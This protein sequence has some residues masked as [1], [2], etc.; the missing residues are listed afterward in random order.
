M[1]LKPKRDRSLLVHIFVSPAPGTVP[2]LVSV[3][4][5]I[6]HPVFILYPTYGSE[7]HSLFLLLASFY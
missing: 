5:M 2:N 1:S 7:G 4:D 3:H 6:S